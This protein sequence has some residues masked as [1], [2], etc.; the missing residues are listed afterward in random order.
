MYN[1]CMNYYSS[2]IDVF[3]QIHGNIARFKNHCRCLFFSANYSFEEHSNDKDMFIKTNAS[4]FVLVHAICSMSHGDILL[5]NYKFLR[6][7]SC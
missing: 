3:P 5:I 2:K 1:M 7:L 6:I 4:L